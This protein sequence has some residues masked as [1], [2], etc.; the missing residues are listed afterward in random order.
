[1]SE[2][3]KE[4][5]VVALEN[6]TV[7]DHIPSDKLFKVVSILGLDKSEKQITIGN[8]LTSKKSGVKGIIKI[9]DKY[10]KADEIDKIALV[11]PNAV[12]NIIK[13]VNPKCIT[14]NQPVPTRFEVVDKK[15]IVVRCHYCESMIGQN[16]IVIK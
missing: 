13:C 1:M 5:V 15:N 16:E 10:F 4:L 9:S 6:G 8:N 2:Q 7:I 11:A 14:N 3:K 12:L